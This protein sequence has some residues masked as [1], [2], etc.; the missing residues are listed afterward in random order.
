MPFGQ[1]KIVS[2]AYLW[3]DRV[4]VFEWKLSGPW[5]KD[6]TG[7]WWTPSVSSL[8]W[9]LVMPQAPIMHACLCLFMTIPPLV[10]NIHHYIQSEKESKTKDDQDSTRLLLF[11]N[12]WDLGQN[13][14]GKNAEEIERVYVLQWCCQSGWCSSLSWGIA[15]F[16]WQ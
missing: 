7:S 3:E 9:E 5:R 2:V 8:H 14:R 13:D 10:W 12:K 15:H 11:E 4:M 6:L 16:I 1:S